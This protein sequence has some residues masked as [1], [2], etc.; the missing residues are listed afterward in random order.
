M[1]EE[2][3]IRKEKNKN[4]RP[5]TRLSSKL[6][7]GKEQIKECMRYMGI[8]V[9]GYMRAGGCGVGGKGVDKGIPIL[10]RQR[11]GRKIGRWL[12]SGK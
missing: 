4:E 9:Y 12:D 7:K 1:D 10:G 5:G 3:K 6:S 8:W 2:R 11:Y